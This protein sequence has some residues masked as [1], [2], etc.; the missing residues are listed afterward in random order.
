MSAKTCSLCQIFIIWT[1]SSLNW[2]NIFQCGLLK[3]LYNTKVSNMMRSSAS[4]N[5][6]L[7]S[8]HWIFASGSTGSPRS[9]WLSWPSWCQGKLY[10]CVCVCVWL[11][12]HHYCSSPVRTVRVCTEVYLIS[13]SCPTGCWWC[14][15]SERIQRREGALLLL[16]QITV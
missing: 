13:G 9:Y 15:W 7:H 11:S 14:P 3:V 10:L 4:W 16:S 8:L 2:H 5:K 12:D 6:T 1:K